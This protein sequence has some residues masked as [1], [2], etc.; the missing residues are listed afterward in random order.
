MP[1]KAICEVD[2]EGFFLE[3]GGVWIQKCWTRPL[4]LASY[5]S[6]LPWEWPEEMPLPGFVTFANGFFP[7]CVGVLRI[8]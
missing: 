5:P 1:A 6:S 8:Y 2:W 7:L 4:N 3:K